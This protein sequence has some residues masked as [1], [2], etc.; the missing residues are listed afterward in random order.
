MLR[1]FLLLLASCSAQAETLSLSSVSPDT[2]LSTIKTWQA[3]YAEGEILMDAKA[4]ARYEKDLSE[5][6]DFLEGRSD[7]MGLNEERRIEFVN[8]Y[9]N[10]RGLTEGGESRGNRKICTRERRQG[11]NLK[12]TV[13]ITAAERARIEKRNREVMSDI[14][15]NGRRGNAIRQ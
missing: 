5:M 9:E 15:R 4:A 13:C 8:D 6:A 14:E 12:Q 3:L 1:I 7:W 11:S 10:L 2:V